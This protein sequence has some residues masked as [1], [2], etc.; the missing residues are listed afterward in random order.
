M[1]SNFC[2]FFVISIAIRFEPVEEL[3]TFVCL[4]LK[5]RPTQIFF[6]LSSAFLTQKMKDK[7]TMAQS[8]EIIVNEFGT[9]NIPKDFGGSAPNIEELAGNSLYQKKIFLVFV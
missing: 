8:Y 9:K 4:Y 6:N 3:N 5:K 2:Q 1:F 7:I